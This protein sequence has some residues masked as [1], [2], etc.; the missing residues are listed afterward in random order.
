MFR[1]ANYLVL[2]SFVACISGYCRADRQDIL[3]ALYS[4]HF[5][6]EENTD[7]PLGF[8]LEGELGVIDSSGNTN[9]TSFNGSLVATHEMKKWSNRYALEGIY[10]QSTNSDNERNTTAQRFNA[11]IEADYKLV[12]PRKRVFIFADYEDNRFDGFDKQASIAA[13]WAKVGIQTEKTELRYSLGPGY[14]V[15]RPQDETDEDTS[16]FIVRA[17]AEYVYQWSSGAR[18]RQSISTTAG[19][20][21]T[22]SRSETSI[23]TKVIDD[24]AMKLS[25]IL[26][27]NSSPGTD[28]EPLDT[29]TSVSLVYQFF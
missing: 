3:N 18:L 24:L 13:G 16:G 26:D 1:F 2:V 19:S 21:T 20:T 15:A 14:N 22:L 7:K 28:I 23:S 17:S 10:T 5:P 27:H 29:R 4:S 11:S 8:S 12:D 6:A 25:F 9:T